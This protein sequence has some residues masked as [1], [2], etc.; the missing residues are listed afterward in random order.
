MLEKAIQLETDPASSTWAW[1]S[2]TYQQYHTAL[3]LLSEVSNFPMRREAD[4]IWK[5][6]DYVFGVD[7]R[8]PR[9]EKSRLIYAR[10][11]EASAVYHKQRK[12]RAPKSMGNPQP[13]A[14]TPI[15]DPQPTQSPTHILAQIDL[16]TPYSHNHHLPGPA[17]GFLGGQ[18]ELQQYGGDISDVIG[19]GQ[20]SSFAVSN[21]G[22]SYHIAAAP[23][24]SAAPAP[25]L[26]A[27]APEAAGA[28]AS[29]AVVTAAAAPAP[30]VTNSN[31]CYNLPFT[32]SQIYIA[33]AGPAGTAGFGGY[34]LGPPCSVSFDYVLPDIDWVCAPPPPPSLPPPLPPPPQPPPPSANM[35]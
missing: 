29:T 16:R 35:A 27:G 10:L 23:A 34:D 14:L 1:Y 26:A 2:G 15:E 33:S 19:D 8:L 18:A 20:A 28:A 3:L 7:A 21:S 22:A 31:N 30:Q 13:L 25:P 11:G 17:A 9:H 6:C 24:F 4:R 32:N 5:C 12:V